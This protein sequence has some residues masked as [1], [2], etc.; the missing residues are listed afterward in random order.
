MALR[1][2]P[3]IKKRILDLINS[4]GDEPSEHVC[5]RL[6]AWMGYLINSARIKN[7]I[8]PKSPSFNKKES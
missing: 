2:T 3:K 7:I 5:M 4:T 6:T 1:D 8:I